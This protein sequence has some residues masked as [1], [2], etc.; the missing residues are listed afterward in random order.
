MCALGPYYEVTWTLMAKHRQ[1]VQLQNFESNVP[2]EA[3]RSLL[4]RTSLRA[5][6]SGSF[7]NREATAGLDSKLNP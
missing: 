5:R 4:A 6:T 3:V 2:R 7:S 1:E